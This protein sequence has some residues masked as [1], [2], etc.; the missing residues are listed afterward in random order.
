VNK[1]F[2]SAADAVAD[3]PDGASLAVGGFGVCGVPMSLI[4]A[5]HALGVRDLKI[6][7]NNC[8]SVDWG[9]GV[10]L[11]DRRI[12]RMISSYIG[13]NA[14]FARQYLA[15]EIEVELT[16]QGTLAERLRAGGSG[17]PAFFT[18][19]GVGTDVADGSLPWLY[20]PDGTIAI[21][22]PAKEVRAFGGRDYL[23]EEAITCD[24]GLVHAAR[25]DPAGNLVFAKAARN[26]NPL[27]AMASRIAIAEVEDLV[28]PG[29]ID[30]DQVHLPGIYVQRVVNVGPGL[31]KPIENRTVRIRG[32][33]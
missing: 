24:F 32:G 28:Q 30:P 22:S 19:S 26:F 21:A 31:D 11:A 18:P 33:L 15:G 6:A 4:T 2:A 25:A 9:L 29:E 7:S 27:C 5:V 3:I 16:P 8:G 12:S 1:V 20:S 14:E 13:D 23:L 10:L 17:I